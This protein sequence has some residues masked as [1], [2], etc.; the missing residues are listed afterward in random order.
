MADKAIVY[1]H[2][3]LDTFYAK[4]C[5][6]LLRGTSRFDILAVIDAAHFGKDAGEVMD[7]RP[8]GIRVF[9]TVDAFLERSS[10]KPKYCV[11]G[12][13]FP[14]GL[15]PEACRSEIIQAMKNGLPIVCGL[16]QLLSDDPEFQRI[17]EENAVEIIDVRIPPL[18]MNCVFGVEKYTR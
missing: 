2:D 3:L 8:I 17:A 7:G 9:R 4:T 10:E 11:V 12:V 6:G 16:H 14:G 15:L 5:H 1:T 13:A 18:L